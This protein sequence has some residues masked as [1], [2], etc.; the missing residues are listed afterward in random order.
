MRPYFT[1]TAT[2]TKEIMT[3]ERSNMQLTSFF[4]LYIFRNVQRNARALNEI[5]L[6]GH[7][8][9]HRHRRAHNINVSP[10]SI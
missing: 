8:A 9:H 6:F 7:G 10:N 4:L 5:S 1:A 3:K 2:T